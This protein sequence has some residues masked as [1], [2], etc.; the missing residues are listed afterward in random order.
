[1][2]RKNIYDKDLGY[3]IL[4]PIVDLNLKYSYRKTQV[5]G[6]DELPKDGPIIFAANHCNTLMDALVILRSS[7]KTTVFGARADMFNNPL[8]AKIM[9]FLRILPMVRQRDGLRN[10]LKNVE[11]QQIIVDTLKNDVRFCIFPEGRHRPAKSLLPF[12]K[13]IFR[14]ALAANADFGDQKPVYI[15]PVGIEYGDFFRYRSTSLVKYGKALNVTE[16]I[17]NN[18]EDTEAH[19]IEMMRKE[20]SQ[21]ISELFTYLKDDENLNEKW[22]LVKMIS[23]SKNRRPYGNCGTDLH[24][25]MTDNREIVATVEKAIEQE[26]QKMKEVLDKVKD[27]EKKRRKDGISIYSF[28]KKNEW[29]NIAGKSLAAI[30]G[31]PYFIFSAV[32]SLPMWVLEVVLRGMIKDKAFRNTASFGVKLGLGLIWFLILT[33]L[34]FCFMPWIPALAVVLLSIPAYSFVH[35]YLEGMRR[36]VSDI[37][38]IRYTKLKK[39][40]SSI[41]NDFKQVVKL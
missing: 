38:L 12:S 37:R 13:G 28:R 35:D 16:F 22:T 9:Y 4:K 31:L 3:T 11:T 7:R 5:I 36:F 26:P 15:V 17:R 24:E 20:L 10:V 29:L 39:R 30:I 33:V 1:M 14:L 6:E 25:C 41:L 2:G 27:F 19:S 34:A 23:V 32:A 18:A 21:R 8:V 40:F